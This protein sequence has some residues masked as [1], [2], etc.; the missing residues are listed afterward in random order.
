MQIADCRSS[1]L[2]LLPSRLVV[3]IV[4]LDDVVHVRL[5]EVLRAELPSLPA[6]CVV[7]HLLGGV[8]PVVLRAGPRDARLLPLGGQG[9][10][11]VGGGLLVGWRHHVAGIH[12]LLVAVPLHGTLAT[13][14]LHCHTGSHPAHTLTAGLSNSL[15]EAD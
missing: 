9:E 6:E 14:R 10:G 7:E 4:N 1:I 2:Y 5:L 15:Q 12:G 13:L 11:L 8:D 3:S